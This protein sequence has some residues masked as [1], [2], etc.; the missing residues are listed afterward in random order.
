[1]PM[2][3]LHFESPKQGKSSV[4]PSFGNSGTDGSGSQVQNSRNHPDSGKEKSG[5]CSKADSI[6]TNQLNPIESPDPVT[7]KGYRGISGNN[8]LEKNL[9][10]NFNLRNNR[11]NEEK[12]ENSEES[13][14]KLMSANS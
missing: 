2:A 14:S 12:E 4:R 11:I 5:L 7:N 1:M 9:D 6:L 13:R 3:I 8:K 10:S